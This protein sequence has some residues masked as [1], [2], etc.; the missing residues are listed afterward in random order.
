[1]ELQNPRESVFYPRPGYNGGKAKTLGLLD[2]ELPD[3]GGG[4]EPLYGVCVVHHGTDKR[5][6]TKTNR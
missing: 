1:M 5:A 3:T 6:P 2:P 4:S